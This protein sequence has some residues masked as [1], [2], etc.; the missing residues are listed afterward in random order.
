MWAGMPYEDVRADWASRLGK[1]PRHAIASGFDALI[2]SGAEWPPTLPEFVKLCKAF[3][4]PEQMVYNALPAPGADITDDE[5][6]RARI[7]AIRV[8]D[9]KGMRPVADG[10]ADLL[11]LISEAA[12]NAGA[13]PAKVLLGLEKA[14]S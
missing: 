1:F 9:R 5:T 3:V 7:A 8:G 10:L 12:G 11:G 4:R 13:D 2:D 6:A 14:F